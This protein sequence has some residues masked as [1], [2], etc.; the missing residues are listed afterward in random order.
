MQGTFRTRLALTLLRVALGIFTRWIG[1][2]LVVHMAVGILL[3]HGP[4]GWYVVGPGHGGAEYN[5]VKIV[6]LLTVM[7]S[8]RGYGLGAGREDR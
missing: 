5:A 1:L 2:L 3:V 8:I 6:A 4:Q 7:I